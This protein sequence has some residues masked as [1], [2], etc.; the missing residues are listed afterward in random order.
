MLDT[1][2]SWDRF[3]AD[4][5]NEE[6]SENKKKKPVKKKSKVSSDL[7]IAKNARSP[8][9]VYQLF[10]KAEKFRK[11]KL[12]FCY[13]ELQKADLELKSSGRDPKL[14]LVNVIFQIC[15]QK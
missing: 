8:Y 9:P 3:F 7:F 1:I 2:E 12:F 4:E 15:L 5:A 13:E 6:K 14:I 10:K 11:E